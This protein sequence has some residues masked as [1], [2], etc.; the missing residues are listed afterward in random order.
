MAGIQMWWN[1]D[2]RDWCGIPNM[3]AFSSIGGI[4][5]KRRS[6][7]GL[8]C[9]IGT[10]ASPGIMESMLAAV[11]AQC[12]LAVSPAQLVPALPLQVGKEVERHAHF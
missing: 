12:I 3:V 4:C 6:A 11:K 5:G 1:I 10:V 7:E 9:T 8:G 2:G